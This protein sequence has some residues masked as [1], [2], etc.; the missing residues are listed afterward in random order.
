MV[1]FSQLWSKVFSFESLPFGLDRWLISELSLPIGGSFSFGL[2]M[3]Y[4]VDHPGL[5]PSTHIGEDLVYSPLG[6]GQIR[7]LKLR[8]G[9]G[10]EN[11]NA[12]LFTVNL[13]EAPP[14]EA[15]SYCWGGSEFRNAVQI[16]KQSVSIPTGLFEALGALRDPTSERLIWADAICINQRDWEERGAQVNIM[17]EIYKNADSVAIYLG[18]PTDRTEEGMRLLRYFTNTNA[19]PQSSP[20]E[21]SPIAELERS[22]LDILD[23][24][25]FKRV[26]TVQEAV[27]A[28]HTSLVSGDYTVSWPGDLRTLRSIVLRIKSAAISPYYFFISNRIRWDAGLVST[29]KY[30]GN[31]NETG[32]KKGGRYP[33]PKPPRPCLRLSA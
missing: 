4:T 23:R 11:L 8:P 3:R 30:S 25:W 1:Y 29:S 17:D 19:P 7:L 26:W 5:P 22:I 12:S 33:L 10:P 15:L 9:N 20:W 27:L 16:G 18:Q 31:S 6:K 13:R 2:W 32:R 21:S 24:P 28:R 14:F